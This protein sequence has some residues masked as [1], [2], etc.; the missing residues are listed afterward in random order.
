MADFIVE[1]TIFE[2]SIELEAAR[3]TETPDLNLP[4]K[5]DGFW[6]MNVDGS[7]SSIGSGAC[8]LV[9]GPNGFIT[10]YALWFNFSM[11]NNEAEYEALL[12]RLRIAR[13]LGVKKL[14][15]YTD[16]QLVAGQVKGNMKCERRI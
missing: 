3:G 16:S 1:Y 5:L 15:I 6:I 14:R 8:L 11:T 4:H 10:K 12:T 9:S 7:A 2:D 13:E